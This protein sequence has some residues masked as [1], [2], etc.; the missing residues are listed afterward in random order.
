MEAPTTLIERLPS[1]DGFFSWIVLTLLGISTVVFVCDAV[2]FLPKRL[3]NF[4]YRNRSAQTI[5]VLKD[6]G[7]EVDRVKRKNRAARIAEKRTADSLEQ[8]A[9]KLTDSFMIKKRLKVGRVDAVQTNSFINLMGASCNP[10][11]AL[12][13]AQLLSSLWRNKISE[14]DEKTI[15]DFD[16]VAAPKAGSPLIAYEFARLHKKPL[17]LH[18]E[19]PKFQSEEFDFASLFDAEEQPEDGARA[20]IVDDSTTGGRKAAET[21]QHL[22]DSGY[23]VSDFLVVFEPLTKKDIGR[24]AAERLS[25]VGVTLHSII[26][27]D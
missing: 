10:I 18:N 2:G 19:N 14:F 13:A 4:L 27:T 11:R 17:V 6:L 25:A 12:E 21:I 8:G 7:F 23:V 1:L 20:I 26:K 15:P 24:N 16:F 9:K 5:E 22:R 3:Q